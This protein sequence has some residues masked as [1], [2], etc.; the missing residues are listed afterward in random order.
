[1]R[2]AGSP[3]GLACLLLLAA[4][5]T[6]LAIGQAARGTNRAPVIL[7]VK[8]PPPLPAPGI[9]IFANDCGLSWTGSG[10]TVGGN[11][12]SNLDA[13]VCGSR[14]KV[15][16][17]LHANRK[18]CVSGSGNV[19]T[20]AAEYGC[21]ASVNG[22]NSL[23]LVKVAPATLAYPIASVI[24][25]PTYRVTKLQVTSAK[26]PLAKGTYY[27]T[28]SIQISASM[29]DLTNIT[30]ACAG[31]IMVSGSGNLFS[32]NQQG[33]VFYSAGSDIQFAGSGLRLTGDVFAPCG[34]V[35][36]SGASGVVTQ[37]RIIGRGVTLRG[38]NW[39]FQPN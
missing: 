37:G 18:L 24:L 39:S 3:R 27:A 11:V 30:F 28:C 12:W 8:P 17:A 5:V 9:L 14:N 33:L 4:G 16:G 36:L 35:D 10:S 34:T 22:A 2:K 21:S 38:S 19:V 32:P 1:M 13:S 25:T 26:P 23:R 20:G 6:T 29:C 31:P 7:T 15:V